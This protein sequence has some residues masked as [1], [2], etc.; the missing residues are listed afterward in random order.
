MKTAKQRANLLHEPSY[1]SFCP[2]N[3]CHSNGG[4]QGKNFN[5]TIK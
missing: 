5:E 4:R 2:K 1:S 3:R